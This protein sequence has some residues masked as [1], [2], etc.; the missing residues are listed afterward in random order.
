VFDYFKADAV[1]MSERTC[2][3]MFSGGRDSTLAAIRLSRAWDRLVLVTVTS[4]DMKGLARVSRRLSELRLLLPANTCWVHVSFQEEPHRDGGA[5]TCLT[6]HQAYIVAGIMVANKFQT[7]HIALGYSGYQSGWAEQTP[8]AIMKLNEVLTAHGFN[9]LL[10]VTDLVRKEDALLEL[11]SNDLSDE[12]LEQK[13]V[14]QI[15]D[16]GLTGDSLHK[17]VDEWSKDLSNAMTNIDQASLQMILTK[18]LNDASF[19]DI[20][21]T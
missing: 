4:A 8:Y 17:E 9:L 19:D 3:L 7:N 14:R 16:P 2:I 20:P 6:C 13:C 10:P 1:E 21:H 12:A 18:H 5:K 15:I 11:R